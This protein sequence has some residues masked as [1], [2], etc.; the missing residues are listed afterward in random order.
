MMFKHALAILLLVFAGIGAWSQTTAAVQSGQMM[1]FRELLTIRNIQLT[2]PSLIAALQN[3]DSQVRAWS[4]LVLAEDKQTDAIPPIS[5]ALQSE[6]VPEA[7]AGIALALGQ[8]RD[9]QGF[10]TLKDMCSASSTPPYVRVYA[11]MYLL[12][13]DDESCLNTVFEVLQS[14]ANSGLRTLAFSQLSRFH[15]LSQ[16]DSERVATATLKALTDETPAMRIAAAKA[17]SGFSSAIAVPALQSAIAKE[18][19]EAVK[20]Q[21]Q[22]SLQR[23]REQETH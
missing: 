19:I 11:T 5:K 8:L 14:N 17:V 23:L 21:M 10:A 3:P 7:K 9:Q 18:Q 2:E 22:S 16:V 1:T 20:V 13:L 6:T 4:A 12:A 15:K